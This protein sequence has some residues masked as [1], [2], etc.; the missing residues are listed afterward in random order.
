M[1]FVLLEGMQSVR[2]YD[3][4]PLPVS[5]HHDG[6]LKEITAGGYVNFMDGNTEWWD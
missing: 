5:I 1:S 4:R 6:A 2:S 3:P